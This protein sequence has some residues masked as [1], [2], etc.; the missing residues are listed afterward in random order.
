MI[1]LPCQRNWLTPAPE[2]N[3]WCRF[4]REQLPPARR[5]GSLPL[6]PLPAEGYQLSK[7]SHPASPPPFLATTFLR[8]ERPWLEGVETWLLT[9]VEGEV[10]TTSPMPSSPRGPRLSRAEVGV[11]S[12]D[13]EGEAAGG[14][15]KPAA[16]KKS[17]SCLALLLAPNPP[18]RTAASPPKGDVVLARGGSA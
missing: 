12:R 13:T 17:T 18:V 11:F 10:A 8:A 5:S 15:S 4:P 16:A 6:R 1:C 14:A 9:C 3:F 2:T 7:S